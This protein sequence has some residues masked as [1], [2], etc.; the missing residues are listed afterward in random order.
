MVISKNSV[1]SII[2]LVVVKKEG[3]LRPIKKVFMVAEAPNGTPPVFL[4]YYAI[5]AYFYIV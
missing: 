3:V 1:K 2:F 5:V 4:L